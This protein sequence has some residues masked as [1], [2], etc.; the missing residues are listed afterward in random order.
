MIEPSQT[1]FDNLLNLLANELTFADSCIGTHGCN[2]QRLLNIYYHQNP[3]KHARLGL[4]YNID[5]DQYVDKAFVNR[6]FVARIVHYRGHSKPWVLDN[7]ADRCR[8]KERDRV[9]RFVICWQWKASLFD[10]FV[11]FCVENDHLLANFV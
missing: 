1:T 10:L 4:T 3:H 2:D 9:R 8:W 7:E 6:S 5:C 11:D